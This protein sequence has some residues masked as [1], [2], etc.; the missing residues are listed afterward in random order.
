M[1]AIEESCIL[2]FYVRYQVRIYMLELDNLLKFGKI[3]KYHFQDFLRIV[4]FLLTLNNS[5]IFCKEPYVGSLKRQLTKTNRKLFD[6]ISLENPAWEIK[7][8]KQYLQEIVKLETL[9]KVSNLILGLKAD[10][11]F[12]FMKMIRKLKFKGY[13]DQL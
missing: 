1:E 2:N 10:K 8:E 5:S 4:F 13:Y 3:L 9:S 7:Y 6:E 11:G 12:E